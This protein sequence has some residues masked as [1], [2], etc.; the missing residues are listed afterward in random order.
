MYNELLK[1]KKHINVLEY[2]EESLKHL[3]QYK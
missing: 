2:K 1:I 3:Y